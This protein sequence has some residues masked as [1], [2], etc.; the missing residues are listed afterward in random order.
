[1]NRRDSL[2]EVIDGQQRITTLL[3]VIQYIKSKFHKELDIF[4]TCELEMENFDKFGLLMDNNF[5]LNDLGE[6]DK[7]LIEASDVFNQR[8]R[9]I[10]LWNVFDQI[11]ALQTVRN[12]RTVLSNIRGSQINLI[13][14]TN[15]T[16]NSSSINYFMDVNLKGVKLDTEDIFKG[17]LF[18][19]DSGKDIRDE[20]KRFKIG[21]FKLNNNKLTDY[22][23]TKLLEHY[24]Y[25][26]LYK[27]SIPSSSSCWI[28]CSSV[29][30]CWSGI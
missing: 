14:N 27:D 1:M 24:F 8:N 26:D 23:T 20:W 17:Y 4:Q 30:A 13:V 18:S 9:Y 25:C 15:D 7:G 2:Y 5:N 29:A 11:Q 22:P 6:S 19:L 28:Y 12:C 10:E 16:D 3:M 21:S